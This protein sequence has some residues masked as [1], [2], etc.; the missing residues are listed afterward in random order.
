MVRLVKNFDILA[1]NIITT[2]TQVNTL[3]FNRE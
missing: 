2:T 3:G 1:H